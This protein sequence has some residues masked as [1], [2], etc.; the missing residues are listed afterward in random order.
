VKTRRKSLPVG[1]QCCNG[2]AKA[3]VA[4]PLVATVFDRRLRLG[5]GLV[6]RRVQFDAVC[7]R[8][9]EFGLY[10]C[11]E[12]L[13]GYRDGI[14]LAQYGGWH[15]GLNGETDAFVCTV[16]DAQVRVVAQRRCP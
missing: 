15:L 11:G 10:R 14:A 7:P 9:V 4:I 16:R 1:W 12:E 5:D 13:A 3:A 2:G 8:V 6:S